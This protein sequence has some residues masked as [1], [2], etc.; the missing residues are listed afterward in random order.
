[1]IIFP[2]QKLKFDL[3]IFITKISLYSP[4]TII[5][6]YYQS[7][8]IGDYLLVSPDHFLFHQQDIVTKT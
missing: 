4:W 2:A 1:M 7:I 8:K 5:W 3:A 6:N